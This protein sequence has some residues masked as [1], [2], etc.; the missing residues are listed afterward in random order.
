MIANS[1]ILNLSIGDRIPDT[2]LAHQPY[3]GV[4]DLYG[5][6]VFIDLSADALSA[7]PDW[8]NVDYLAGQRIGEY[9]FKLTL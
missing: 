3:S 2:R 4:I 8:I 9:G 1:E 6:Q 5:K 7:C